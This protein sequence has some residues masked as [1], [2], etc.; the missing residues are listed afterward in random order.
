[1]S[2]SMFLMH[3]L[4]VLYGFLSSG[5]I[6]QLSYASYMMSECDILLKVREAFAM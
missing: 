6:F 5:R 4:A 2:I 1:M 3:C